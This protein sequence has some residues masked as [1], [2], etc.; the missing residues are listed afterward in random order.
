LTF[1]QTELDFLAANRSAAMITIGTDGRSKAVRVGVAI[2]DGKL[3]S[4]GTRHRVRTTRLLRDPRC[5]VFVFGDRLQYLSLEGTVDVLDGP[6]AGRQS[7]QLFR[8]MQGR[9]TGPLAW[10]GEELEEP[11][12]LQRMEEEG[13]IIYEIRPTRSYGLD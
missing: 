9:P 12:F 4:S 10:Y 3:W 5:S 11:E 13:R 6:D 8:V 2:V 1:T 7:L